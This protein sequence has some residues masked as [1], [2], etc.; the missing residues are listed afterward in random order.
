MD[1]QH[2]RRGQGCAQCL[3]TG[4][5]ERIAVIELLE[6]TDPMRQ[7]IYQGTVRELRQYLVA[8][9]DDAGRTAPRVGPAG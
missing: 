5:L 9:D 6:V 7:F 4:Y 2:W 3:G 1:A 8:I